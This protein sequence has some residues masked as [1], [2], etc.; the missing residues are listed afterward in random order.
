VKAAL[1]ALYF[2]H[3]R[4]DSPFNTLLLVSALAFVTLFLGL[5]MLDTKEYQ[6]EVINRP[7]PVGEAPTAD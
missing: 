2:M 3:L 7:R 5:T 4:Y 6:P 1:V